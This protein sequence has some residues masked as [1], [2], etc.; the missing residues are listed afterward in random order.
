MRLTVLLAA[1]VACSGG[2]TTDR[3]DTIL[4]LTG[5]PTNG[6]AVYTANC[7]VCHAASGLGVDDPETPGTGVNL[8]EAAGETDADAEFIPYIIDGVGDMTAF[9]D[10]LSDQDIADVLAYLH[11]GLIQ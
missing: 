4:G 10:T 8:T 3:V 5:D 1:L 11:D 6:E 2:G 7:A 9:G